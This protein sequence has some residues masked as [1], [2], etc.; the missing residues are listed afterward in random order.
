VCLMPLQAKAIFE[1][2]PF[3]LDPAERL[4]LREKVPVQLPPK[5]FDA[6]V[7]MVESRGRLLGKDELLRAVWPDSFVEESNLALYISI[8]RKALR[9]GEDGLQCIE[10]VPRHG[11]RFVAE[12]REVADARSE[13][14]VPEPVSPWNHFRRPVFVLATVLVILAAVLISIL[15]IWKKHRAPGPAPI[16][17]LAVLPLQNLSGDPAQQYLADGMTEAL[18]TDVAKIP[19]LKVI[20]RTSIMQYKD[21]NKRLPI[22]AQELGYAS[23]SNWCAAQPISTSGRNLTNGIC[24]TW[25]LCRAKFLAVSLCKYRRKSHRRRRNG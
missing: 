15:P 25:S 21:S 8:L 4:L 17:S 23:P 16:Q 10:T 19:G 11:Y 3:R 6:L 12:V 20:S 18:I 2:G 5:V 1:F 22:I 24:A 7:V 14:I 9:D 13:S